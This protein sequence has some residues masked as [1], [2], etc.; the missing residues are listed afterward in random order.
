MTD[1][2]AIVRAFENR[3]SLDS[4]VSLSSLDAKTILVE[5]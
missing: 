5:V 4:R 1:G 2:H 3:S